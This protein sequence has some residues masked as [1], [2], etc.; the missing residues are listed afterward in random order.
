MPWLDI[1]NDV[2]SPAYN[3]SSDDEIIFEANGYIDVLHVILGGTNRRL[4]K[5]K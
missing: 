4:T 3:F 5:I 1:I 2:T